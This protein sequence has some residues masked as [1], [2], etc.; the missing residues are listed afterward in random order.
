MRGE[1]KMMKFK[2][3]MYMIKV[4]LKKFIN[5]NKFKVGIAV[6]LVLG[7]LLVFGFFKVKSYMLNKITFLS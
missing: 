5:R 7:I 2:N 4:K 3:K 1:L 6:S